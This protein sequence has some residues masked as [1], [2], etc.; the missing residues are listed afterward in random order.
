M[1]R[2]EAKQIADRALEELQQ[3]LKAGRSETLLRFL[4]VM[5]WGSRLDYHLARL[6]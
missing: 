5:R 1:K 3:A 4:D 6:V 2:D